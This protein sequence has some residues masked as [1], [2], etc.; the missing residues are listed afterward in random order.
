LFAN[1][2]EDTVQVVKYLLDAKAST[3]IT[4][5]EGT[6]LLGYLNTFLEVPAAKEIHDLLVAKG[7]K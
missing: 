3:D 2:T 4:F 7:V 5:P 6:S 1:Y